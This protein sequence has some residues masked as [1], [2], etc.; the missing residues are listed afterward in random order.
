[1]DLS[2]AN[3]RIEELARKAIKKSGNQFFNTLQKRILAY[4]EAVV[5]A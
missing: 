2:A 5:T 4:M 3:Q 1:M